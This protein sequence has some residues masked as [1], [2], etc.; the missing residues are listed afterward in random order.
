MLRPLFAVLATLFVATAAQTDSPADATPGTI[1]FVAKNLMSTADGTF[2]AWR[3]VEAAIDSADPASGVVEVEVDVASVDTGIERRDDHLRAADFF[4]VEKFP[5][6]SVRV[7]R[8][9]SDGESERGHPRYRAKFDIRIRDVEK[10]LD[11]SFELVSVSPP[12][13]EG[14]LTLN[15]VDFGVGDPHTWWN[16]ASI[17]EE[18]PIR[19]SASFAH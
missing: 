6:A 18:I 9:I 4:E 17:T 16:P 15:R 10:T 3:I 13:V 14:E 11:G 7:H 8:A 19:F 12:T 1:T 5:T 2:H